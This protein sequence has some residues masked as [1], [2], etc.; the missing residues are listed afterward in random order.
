MA[1]ACN[2]GEAGTDRRFPAVE[3]A[4]LVYIRDK[5]RTG[6]SFY[7]SPE[8]NSDA[9]RGV[10][11]DEFS[12]ATGLGFF[13]AVIAAVA[14][15]ASAIGS[16]AVAAAPSIASI[17]GSAA[18]IKTANAANKTLATSGI[19]I[20]NAAA[21]QIMGAVQQDIMGI[22]PS[23]LMLLGGGAVIFLLARK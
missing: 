10:D 11:P 3:K 18:A 15:A 22:S 9:L 1:C 14:T 16:A 2:L 7:I 23:L 21:P 8:L 6:E 20:P 4:L 17:Y 12:R 5:L 13:Q 19:A